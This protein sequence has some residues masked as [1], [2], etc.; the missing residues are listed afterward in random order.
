M[1]NRFLKVSALLTV[2]LVYVYVLIYSNVP[3]SITL[4]EGKEFSYPFSNILCLDCSDDSGIKAVGSHLSSSVI[5]RETIRVSLFGKIP[6]KKID[7]N[8]ISKSVVLVDG[9]MIGMKLKTPGLTVV[10]FEEFTGRDYRKVRP[11]EGLNIQR[12]DMITAI[13]GESVTDVDMFVDR[14]QK[15]AG[16]VLTLSILRNQ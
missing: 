3:S 7:V 5:G 10:T 14:I 15:S 16:A 11:Y 1:K 12:G 4:I 13:N 9:E 8:V 2:L 6:L